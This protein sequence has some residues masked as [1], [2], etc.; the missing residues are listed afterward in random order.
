MSIDPHDLPPTP[1]RVCSQ[2]LIASVPS[3]PARG[4]LGERLREH[5]AASL[6]RNRAFHTGGGSGLSTARLVTAASD[7]TLGAL[8]DALAPAHKLQGAVLVGVGG[9]GRREMSPG[10][11][12]DLL[13]LHTEIG[14]AHV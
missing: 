4:N 12:W 7:A 10:S 13:L 11:D 6:D 2:A 3:F 8:W 9:T 1:D 14:R 5:R